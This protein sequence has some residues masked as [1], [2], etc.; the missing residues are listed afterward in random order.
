M[1]N[2]IQGM[3]LLHYRSHVFYMHSLAPR[4]IGKRNTKR[5]IETEIDRWVKGRVSLE[6]SRKR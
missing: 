6:D 4:V 5:N 2:S 3:F 1:G